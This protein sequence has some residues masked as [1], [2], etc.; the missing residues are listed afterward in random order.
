M[1]LKYVKVDLSIIEPTAGVCTESFNILPALIWLHSVDLAISRTRL[2][3]LLTHTLSSTIPEES[4]QGR[5]R[6][7]TKY[8]RLFTI[9][10]GVETFKTNCTLY[11]EL[12]FINTKTERSRCFQFLVP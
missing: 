4:K 3:T 9:V 11:G 7:W 10:Q 8:W 2:L 12:L 5:L 1:T 6:K